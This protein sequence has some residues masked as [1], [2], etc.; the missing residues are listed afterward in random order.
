MNNDELRDVSG[1]VNDDRLLVGLLYELMRDHTPTGVIEGIVQRDE[2]QFHKDPEEF[3]I[4]FTNGHLAKY[5]QLL[6]TRLT[7]HS[8]PTVA[9]LLA[10]S[11]IIKNASDLYGPAIDSNRVDLGDVSIEQL[12]AIAT[13]MTLERMEHAPHDRGSPP[14]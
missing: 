12:E 8:H 13:N 3:H 6:A 5:A 9:R 10:M 11:R 7:L 14:D 2:E 1:R 4:K